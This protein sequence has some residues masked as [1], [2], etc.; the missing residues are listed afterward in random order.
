MSEWGMDLS[1]ERNELQGRVDRPRRVS[2]V[3]GEYPGQEPPIVL[4][5]GFPDNLDDVI[6]QQASQCS[7]A[8]RSPMLMLRW[9]AS[10]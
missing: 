3:R 7:S 6:S 1:I 9:N 10:A 5:H 4:M 2:D 8:S